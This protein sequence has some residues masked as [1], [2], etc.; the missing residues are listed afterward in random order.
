[1]MTPILSLHGMDNSE[2][3]ITM[4][5]TFL[6]VALPIFNS[7]AM[8]SRTATDR[9]VELQTV[10]RCP[11][12]SIPKRVATEALIVENEAPV[13][14]IVPLWCPSILIDARMRP[15]FSSVIDNDPGVSRTTCI[16]FTP[17]NRMGICDGLSVGHIDRCRGVH[18]S[19]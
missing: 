18:M 5:T 3:G 7:F 14:S 17:G 4:N 13:S 12:I 1:M 19:G 15:A 2:S 8:S 9:R 16:G 6:I 10:T 11:N